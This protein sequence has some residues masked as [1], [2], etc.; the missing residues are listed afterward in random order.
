M[1]ANFQPSTFNFQHI[2]AGELLAGSG[3]AAPYMGWVSPTYAQKIP[4][5]SWSIQADVPLPFTFTSEW[6]FPDES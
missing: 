4:A 1:Q 3:K 6:R 5:L 2:R